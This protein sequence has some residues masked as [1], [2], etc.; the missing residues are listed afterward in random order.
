M[1]EIPKK[2]LVTLSL[3]LAVPTQAQAQDLVTPAPPPRADVTRGSDWARVLA[4]DSA[5]DVA[6]EI[7]IWSIDDEIRVD[8]VFPDGA[9]MEA[10]F[11]DGEV[12]GI[13]CIDCESA[14]AQIDAVLV[15]LPLPETLQASWLKCAGYA[16]LTVGELATGH[17]WLAVP[18]AVLAACECLEAYD[19]TK[20]CF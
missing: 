6:A 12:A 2:F 9:S 17:P 1:K 18:T 8:A 7:M 13:D 20:E 5:G 15:D 19:E 14:R 3:L 4:Y 11:I 16:A 10:T